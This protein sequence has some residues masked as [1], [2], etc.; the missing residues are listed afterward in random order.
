MSDSMAFLAGAAFTGAAALVL[1]K[2]GLNLDPSYLSNSALPPPPPSQTSTS[3]LLPPPPAATPAT[4]A[5]NPE[6]RLDVERLKDRLEEQRNDMA[7]LKDIMQRQERQIETLTAQLKENALN[8]KSNPAPAPAPSQQPANQMV[9]GIVWA[10]AGI[11]LTII[12]GII[13]AAVFILIW[14]QQRSPR[15]VQVIQPFNSG[16]PMPP[17]GG[18]EFLPPRIR[19]RQVDPPDYPY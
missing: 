9:L 12:V 3:A 5:C 16:H 14:Q 17:R 1:L 19:G 4:T 2:G 13:V 18:S 7:Q 8:V 15:T 11:V 6:Q 10:L